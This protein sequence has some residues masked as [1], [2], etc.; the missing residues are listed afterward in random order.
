M[1]FQ[2]YYHSHKNQ[3]QHIEHHA[4]LRQRLPLTSEEQR[5]NQRRRSTRG[6]SNR[7]EEERNRTPVGSVPPFPP[8]PF[9]SPFFPFSLIALP[10]MCSVPQRVGKQ[11]SSL[12]GIPLFGIKKK[13][14][15]KEQ[16]AGKGKSWKRQVDTN[17][18]SIDFEGLSLDVPA[19]KNDPTQCQQCSAYMSSL[20]AVV[21]QP[22]GKLH[23]TC[24]FCS[25]EMVLTNAVKPDEDTFEY[26]VTAPPTPMDSPRGSHR[27][28]LGDD[29]K[30]LFV[31]DMSGSMCVTSE[32]QGKFKLRT[33]ANWAANLAQEL[34]DASEGD[35]RG[36][37]WLP[38]QRRNVTWV[39]RMQSIQAAM[40]AQLQ[41]IKEENPKTVAGLITFN[42]EV[43]L[44]GDGAALPQVI[45]GTTLHSYDQLTS[46]G[47]NYPLQS[48]IED[49]Y[50]S[51]TTKMYALEETGPTALG[52]A[53]VAGLG[54][55]TAGGG[56]RGSKLIL[57]TDG[58]AN[59][60]LGALDELV[61]D[62]QREAAQ[63]FYSNLGRLAESKGITIDVIGIGDRDHSDLENLGT[64][65]DLTNGSVTKIDPVQLTT[66][67]SSVLAAPLLASEVSIRTVLHQSLQFRGQPHE[68]E[69]KRKVAPSPSN[70]QERCVGNVTKESEVSF[71][72]NSKEG[73]ELPPGTDSVPFQVQLRYTKR[74]GTKCLRVMTQ[75]Q[76]ITRSQEKAEA[77][78]KLSI[79]AGHAATKAAEIARQGKY[80]QSRVE[81][82]AWSNL[83]K[84]NAVTEEA[85]EEYEK[86]AND[87]SKLDEALGG[88]QMQEQARAIVYDEDDE[89]AQ[90]MIQQARKAA[91]SCS[92]QDSLSAVTYNLKK[93]SAKNYLSKKK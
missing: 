55:L 65:A 89:A 66:N 23:W 32:V 91:R 15:P 9:P 3:Q 90:G 7:E 59:V 85:N 60:G 11:Q 69:R 46:L 36:P 6:I 34:A 12:S 52:P 88:V 24:D 44:I 39:S 26:V 58:L 13:K 38:N 93:A 64:M 42:G 77:A 4:Q 18:F 27:R 70:L 22:D 2:S 1:F 10:D 20:S 80:E 71:E 21:V 51:L 43:H 17:I 83:L 63:A 8:S 25:H 30:V 56:G 84:R 81:M 29:A 33:G 16:E 37:Q 40:D 61:T 14:A 35:A 48:P 53:V 76:K 50:E 31:V 19:V 41:E 78:A 82:R 62:E 87:M 5:V 57:C 86:F 74:D 54:M 49:T 45:S 67:F 79:I 75:N 73:I 92:G 47:R 28:F 72:Y 68:G